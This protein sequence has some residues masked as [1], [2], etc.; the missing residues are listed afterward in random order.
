PPSSDDV[1]LDPATAAEHADPPVHAPPA[2]CFQIFLVRMPL[3]GL[4]GLQFRRVS[5]PAW[6]YKDIC[7]D[8]LKRLQL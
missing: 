3:L 5:G 6:Q 8:I 7:S 2:I 1:L 4:C